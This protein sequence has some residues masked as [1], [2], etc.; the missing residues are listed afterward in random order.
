MKYLKSLLIFCF[1]TMSIALCMGQR[2]KIYD[3]SNS[4]LIDNDLKAVV[5]D[6]N[7]NK[8]LGTLKNGL[9]KFD[10]DTF[11]VF[12]KENS[13]V[14]GDCVTTLFVDSKGNLWADYSNP[15]E[16]IAMYDGKDW[17]VFKANDIGIE[18]IDICDICETSNGELWFASKGKAV[19]YKEGSWSTMKIPNDNILC[20]DIRKDGTIAVGGTLKLLIGTNGKWKKY[21]E[22]N[23]E[24]QLGT[25]RSLKFRPDGALIIGYGGGFGGGGFSI[26]S[27]NFKKWTHYNKSNSRIPDHMIRDIEFDGT[28]YWMASNNGLVRK[29]NITMSAIFFREGMFKNVIMDIALEGNTVWIATNFGLIKYKP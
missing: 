26:L 19:I 4:G 3:T 2:T 21:T 1:C 23:S 9:I 17:T 18:S 29:D 14:K 25:I 22:K 10:G 7:G 15:E 27:N 16:G 6:N 13:V 24:L 5:V 8:W 11:T 12:N 28:N 20:M